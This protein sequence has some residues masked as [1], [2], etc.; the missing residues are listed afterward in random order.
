MIMSKID[1]I[2]NKITETRDR[3]IRLK[4]R[5]DKTAAELETLYNKKEELELEELLEAIKGSDKTRAE[6]L[7]FLESK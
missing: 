1:T 2:N 5:Y 7:A 6:V 3:L 4:E